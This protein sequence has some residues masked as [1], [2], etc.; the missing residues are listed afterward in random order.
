M[1]HLSLGKWKIYA[2]DEMDDD[3]REEYEEH[4]YSCDHC[5]VLYM[6]A[7]ESVQD[8]L[9][10][11]E[12]PSLY[13]DEVMERIPFEGEPVSTSSRKHWYEENLFQ[14]VLAMAMT[15]IL[16][17]TGIFGDLLKVTTEFEK[18]RQP[19]FTENVLNKTTALLEDVEKVEEQ[20]AE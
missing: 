20:E 8:E 11:I 12:G 3:K 19:S 17:A 9:P 15:L 2:R 16:M 18:N 6:E 4:L 13:T 14:Y 7:I 10:S 5:M 1:N